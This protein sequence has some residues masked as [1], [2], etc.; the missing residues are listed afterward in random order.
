MSHEIESMAYTNEVPWHGLGMYIADAPNI[1]EMLRV[2]EINWRVEKRPMMT[3]T[4][5]KMAKD[6]PRWSKFTAKV[7]GF[8]ALTRNTDGKVLDVVGNRYT[9]TQ[10]SEAFEFFRSFVEAGDAKMETAGS[11]RG[12]QYVWGLANLGQTFKVTEKDEV[13]TY[14]LVAAPHQQGKALIIKR[15]H[16]RVVCMNTLTAALREGGAEFRMPHRGK[17]DEKQI[18][19]AKV[20]LGLAREEAEQFERDAKTLKNLEISEE[21]AI[22]ILA[23]IMAPRVNDSS[24]NDMVEDMEENG[25]PRMR[26][27]MDAYYRAPGAD[28]GNGWGLLNAVTYY[29]DHLASRTS[30]KRLT[31]A[32][33]GKTANQKRIVLNTL[34]EMAK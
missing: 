9:P 18:E 30:D 7:P 6:E 25:T 22:R 29:A 10:N 1:E 28:P 20:L 23:E 5:M 32:W 17:F 4:E 27:L 12:G 11:L 26:R 15:V 16:L 19:K 3:A 8:Y 14:I 2:A 24:V 33:F 34:L 21:A 13:K 31:N